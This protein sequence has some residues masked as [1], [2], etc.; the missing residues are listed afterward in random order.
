MERILWL[1]PKP[2]KWSR[3]LQNAK[4]LS[5]VA[6][7]GANAR[8]SMAATDGQSEKTNCWIRFV[9]QRRFARFLSIRHGRGAASAAGFWRLVKPPRGPRDLRVSRWGRR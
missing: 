3:K 5:S 6:A 4:A 2:A 8:R 9:M 7:G 1:K